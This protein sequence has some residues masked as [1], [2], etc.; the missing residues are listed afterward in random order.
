[1]HGVQQG[2]PIQHGVAHAQVVQGHVVQGHVP[3]DGYGPGGVVNGV[4]P[5]QAVSGVAQDPRR[6]KGLDFP[7]GAVLRP[8]FE[9]DWT[10][11][12]CGCCDTAEGGSCMHCMYAGCCLPCMFGGN[13]CIMGDIGMVPR[14]TTSKGWFCGILYAIGMT[15][16]LMAPLMWICGCMNRGEMATVMRITTQ[17]CQDC[18]AHFFCWACAVAQERREI[19]IRAHHQGI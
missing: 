2:Q 7:T 13:V 14:D 9:A 4:M 5:S 17:G 6:Q 3:V 1:M 15:P 11:T 18:L 10:A 19:W 16:V 8:P 12:L